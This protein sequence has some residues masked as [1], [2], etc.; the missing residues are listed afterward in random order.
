[1][2]ASEAQS[3]A[4][5]AEARQILVGGVS[6]PVRAFGRVGGTP[7]FIASGHGSRVRD[8]DGNEYVDY[9][10]SWGALILGHGDPRVRQ[11]INEAA[12]DGWTF[13]APTE[14]EL[15]FAQEI[16]RRMPSIER[17]RFVSSGTEATMSALRVARAATGRSAFLKFEGAYHG[18]GDPF[19]SKAGSGLATGDMPDSAGVPPHV[20]ADAWTVAYNDLEAVRTVIKK[21]GKGLAAIFVEPVAANM[22][23]VLPKP[24]FLAGLREICDE[25][26]TLLVFDEVI[27]GFR[28]H[29]GGAQA[30]FGVQPDLTTVGKV[31]GGGLP[32]AAY[33]GREDLMRLVAPEGPVYQAGTLAGNPLAVAAGHATL[34]AMDSDAYATLESRSAALASGLEQALGPNVAIARIGSLLGLHFQNPPPSDWLGSKSGNADRYAQVFHALMARGV[35]FAPSPFEAAF[36]SLAHSKEDVAL[37][38]EAARSAAADI[39]VFP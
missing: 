31:V 14:R 21:E 36:V 35:Y 24:G 11:A 25:Q 17:L 16:R 15:R 20:A 29:P 26:G 23:V 13:G 39:E 7:R 22:N 38:V 8:A 2:M 19:L 28:V 9:V 30:A 6:S 34:R 18:H 12:E 4:L 1:M 32:L 5:L 10:G 27:T 33:G 3:R 37:T